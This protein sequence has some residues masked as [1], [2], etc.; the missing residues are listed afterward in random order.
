MF[1]KLI[2]LFLQFIFRINKQ[3]LELLFFS[4]LIKSYDLIFFKKVIK[5]GFKKLKISDGLQIFLKLFIR[6]FG[7]S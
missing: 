6:L 1:V 4:K 5:D 7:C 2:Q 3:V